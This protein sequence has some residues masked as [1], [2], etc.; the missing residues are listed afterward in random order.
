MITRAVFGDF[1]LQLDTDLRCREKIINFLIEVYV[2]QGIAYAT[3]L[4]AIQLLDILLANVVVKRSELVL[5][6]CACLMLASK[7]EEIYVS[8]YKINK[9][10]SS[11]TVD[12]FSL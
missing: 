10:N 4:H 5:N 8:Q 12:D 11:R 7:L 3:L 9:C 1:G 6:S 2:E